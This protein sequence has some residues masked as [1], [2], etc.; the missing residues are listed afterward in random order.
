MT[1][2]SHA[3][4]KRRRGIRGLILILVIVGIVML[5]AASLVL[6]TF[7][8]I[9]QAFENGLYAVLP[10]GFRNSRNLEEENK[11][12]IGQVAI[13]TAAN[14][15]RNV[16]ANENERLKASLGRE[17]KEKVVYAAIVKRPPGSPYDTFILDAGVEVG[18]QP[19]QKVISGTVLIGEIVEAGEGFSKAKLFSSP[20]NEFSGMLAG[21]IQIEAKG[22][23]GGSFEVTLPIGA[24]VSLGDSLTLPAISTKIF[25]L[26]QNITEKKDEGFKKIL[27]SLPINPN[28]IDSVGII[29]K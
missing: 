1:Y 6:K 8:S 16:L 9:G 20:G 5:F 3:R 17:E 13:L 12:L 27:F 26:V 2:L 29:I 15:D 21:N 11:A 23:G 7:S 4:P 28:Q 22:L 10:E 14:A 25:G 18:I 19:G 24:S